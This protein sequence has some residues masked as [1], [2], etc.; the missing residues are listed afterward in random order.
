MKAIINARVVTP[1]IVIDDGFILIDKNRISKVGSLKKE[2]LPENADIIDAGGLYAGPGFIDIHCHGGG[3]YWCHTNPEEMAAHH[4]K[5]GTTSLVCTIY[6]TIGFQGTIDGIELIK[7]AFKEK[8]P[9]NIIGIH[10]EGPY[11]SP[12]YGA[13]ASGI[14]TPIASEY[15]AYIKHAE[16]LM[17]QWT[18]SPELDGLDEFVETAVANGIP[19]S[20]GHSEAGPEQVDKYVQKGVSIVTHL[21]DA[22]GSSIVPSRFAGT[23]EPSFDECAMVHDLYTE[24]IPDSKGV[25]VRPT[26]LKLIVKTMG[27]DR[28]MIVTDACTGSE[29]GQGSNSQA[30]QY[31]SDD[32]RSAQDL[33]IVNGEL[34]GSKLTM[35]QACQNMKK[36]ID[37]SVAEIFRM[38]A[39]NPAR[40]IRLFDEIGS[41]EKGKKANIVLVDEEFNVQ[42]VILDGEVLPK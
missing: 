13:A 33:N 29:P 9:G 18:F 8:K 11:L 40:A 32:M 38:G 17:R 30:E 5:H 4:L 27:Y 31:P 12:K 2:K 7:K 10:L 23:R 22:T 3:R 39:E 26:M 42:K 16:G 14:I 19:L 6:K 37:C 15:N 24:V 1:N 34:Y 25:H 41:L 36:H 20:I 28:V 21:M 35:D